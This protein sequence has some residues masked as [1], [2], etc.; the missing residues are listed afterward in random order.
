MRHQ[1]ADRFCQQVPGAIAFV[2]SQDGNLRLFGHREGVV[3]LYEG[4]T[5]EDWVVEA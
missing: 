3:H 5:P 1:S 2:V 4:P